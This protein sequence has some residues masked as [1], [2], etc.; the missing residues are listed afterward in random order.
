MKNRNMNNLINLSLL[1]TLSLN[2]AGCATA[3]NPD[4]PIPQNFQRSYQKQLQAS[5]HWE[6]VADDMANQVIKN[7]QSRNALDTPIFIAINSN[8]SAFSQALHDFL[9]AKLIK[10]GAKVSKSRDRST[11]VD[12]KIQVIKFNSKRSVTLPAQAPL[13]TLAGGVVVSRVLADATDLTGFEQALIT[14]GV[15]ADLWANDNAPKLELLVSASII[16]NSIYK[17]KIT[18]IYYA[19][20]EDIN[21]YK[22]NKLDS[23]PFDDAFFNQRRSN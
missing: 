14:G 16:E 13:T 7:L 23:S 6:V 15:L 22:N 19:N 21:L 11:V 1:A 5:Q 17:M 12:Y 10:K 8:H 3:K 9:I 2:L 20:A 18:D 4:A